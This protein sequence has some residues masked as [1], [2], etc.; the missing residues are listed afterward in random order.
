MLNITLLKCEDLRKELELEDQYKAFVVSL[1]QQIKANELISPEQ[2][3]IE[4]EE[5]VFDC[6]LKLNLNVAGISDRKIFVVKRDS[7]FTG[8]PFNVGSFYSSN[9]ENGINT[10]LSE[11]RQ[12]T[13]EEI[14]G[15]SLEKIIGN[16]YFQPNWEESLINVNKAI[17][18]LS[19]FNDQSSSIAWVI[20]GLEIVKNTIELVLKQPDKD[21]FYFQ[22][23]YNEMQSNE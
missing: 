10:I 4:I 17:V 23:V 5:Q 13:L 9:A 22:W 8:H 21:K 3:A 7:L 14:F 15:Y 6:A 16:F 2:Q 11:F 18:G 19:I 12:R 1:Y 20:E